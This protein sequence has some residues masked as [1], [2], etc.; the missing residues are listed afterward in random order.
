VQPWTKAG[1]VW[2]VK[3]GTQL[4]QS[5]VCHEVKCYFYLV[6]VESLCL[7]VTESRRIIKLKM[8]NN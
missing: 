6:Y 1:E 4:N 8:K 7:Q 2:G 3:H 5:F